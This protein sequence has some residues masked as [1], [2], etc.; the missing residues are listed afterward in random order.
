M[1]GRARFF[2]SL[3]NIQNK[4]TNPVKMHNDYFPNSHILG[5][6][7][8]S[9]MMK[10]LKIYDDLKLIKRRYY[11]IEKRKFSLE[12]ICEQLLCMI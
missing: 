8:L 9:K 1:I 5:E 6:T 11:E 12:L 7:S 10:A 4:S 2:D 3:K